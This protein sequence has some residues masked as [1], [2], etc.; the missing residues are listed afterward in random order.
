MVRPDDCTLTPRQH[1]LV[2]KHARQALQSAGAFG[3]FPTPVD[4]VMEA[5]E[6]LVAQEDLADKG[7]LRKMRRKAKSAGHT[8]KRALDKILG[9]MH[10]T[11]RLV[12]FDKAVHVAKLP[13]LKLHE[14]AH[15][16]LPWQ[17]DIYAVTEDCKHTLAPEIADEFER[18]ANVFATEAIFQLDS[19]TK[20]AADSDTNILVPVRLSRRYGASIYSSIR[21][22]VSKHHKA[23]LVLVLEP[24][25]IDEV[26]GFTCK[27]RRV[28]P[29]ELFLRHFGNLQWPESFSPDDEIGAAVPVGGKRMS[30]RRPITLVDQ[31]GNHNRCIGEAFTQTH[32]VFI[33]IHSVSTLSAKRVLVRG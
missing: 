19:F 8:L 16:V 28:V 9:V 10:I 33:L 11:A 13:F 29:S 12:Y 2:R 7:F 18:E 27:L 14:T 30:G 31:N 20:E 23:C 17:K 15:A 21:R 32:Q 5:A 24:P 3:V 26:R 22:Y 6:I 4:A 1:R 25:V